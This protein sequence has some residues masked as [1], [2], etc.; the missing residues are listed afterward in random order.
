MLYLSLEKKNQVKGE[1]VIKYL[2]SN[3]LGDQRGQPLQEEES[4]PKKDD[5]EGRGEDFLSSIFEG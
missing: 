2:K 4:R 3:R 1:R 5:A